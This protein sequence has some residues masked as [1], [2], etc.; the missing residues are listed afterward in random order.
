M[1]SCDKPRP[2]RAGGGFWRQTRWLVGL[3]ALVLSV[4]GC[5]MV[6]H[7]AGATK[8][9]IQSLA[10]LGGKEGSTNAVVALQGDVMREADHYVAAVAQAADDLR[11]RV[12]TLEARNM[13]QQWKLVEATVAY[14][15]ATGENPLYNAVDLVVL[16]TLS[17]MVAEDYWVGEKFGEAA[18]PLLETHR[19]QE[20][21]AWSVV[22]QFLSPE[23]QQELSQL[24]IAHRKR[25]P[26]LRFVTEVRLPELSA[27]LNQTQPEKSSSGT[28]SLF[29]LL[30]LNPLAGL[31]PTTQAIQQSRLL[32]QRAMYY[33]QRAPM[34]LGWQV[35]MTTYQLATQPESRALLS[36][37]DEVAKATTVFAQTAAEMPKLVNEQREAA[38]NQL[39]AGVANERSNILATLNAQE[40][41]LRE[42]LPQVR[43]TLA[44]GS[45]MADSVN[46]AVKSLDA[47]VRYVSPPDTNPAPVS[48]NSKPFNVLDYGTAAS[49]VG[50]AAK[51]LNTLL[52]SLDQSLPQVTRL[53][54]QAS[55]EAKAVTNHAFR[56]GLVLIL[57]LLVGAVLAGLL[58]RAL[59]RERR[60]GTDKTGTG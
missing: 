34:L 24:L 58:W 4:G 57:V 38:I 59:T 9:V 50:V 13:A 33:A 21:N 3:S 48:T 11:A 16:A 30:Y 51:E 53:S 28:G 39:L 14:A 37:V 52:T 47:F 40:A 36:D 20:S 55:A 46:G 43:E 1:N 2:S 31:D 10:G 60:P 56:L 12:G 22:Q 18:R 26:H 27:A 6:E 42:L 35:E 29:N 17:R 5:S 15:A 19:R 25:Q 41:Q 7:G 23:Q 8:T 54:G 45:G 32:A 44:A 49:Q